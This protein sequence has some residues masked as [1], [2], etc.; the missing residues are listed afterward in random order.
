[1]N[2]SE[3]FFILPKSQFNGV[4]LQMGI[5]LVEVLFVVVWAFFPAAVLNMRFRMNE[6]LRTYLRLFSNFVLAC[7]KKM[8]LEEAATMLSYQKYWALRK[9]CK[10]LGVVDLTIFKFSSREWKKTRKTLNAK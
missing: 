1:M 10:I 3:Q 6:C 9:K 5:N 4:H 7:K 2:I 8:I